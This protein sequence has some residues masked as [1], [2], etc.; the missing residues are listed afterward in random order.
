MGQTYGHAVA[1]CYNR[2][3]DNGSSSGD[4]SGQGQGIRGNNPLPDSHGYCGARGCASEIT[5]GCHND[6]SP[7][8]KGTSPNYCSNRIGGIV[9]T[10][11]NAE[12]E[13][14]YNYQA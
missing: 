9:K 4:D 6:G 11:R 13:G 3:D 10:I 12:A 1:C 2:P 7:G 5:K 8:G 14:Y